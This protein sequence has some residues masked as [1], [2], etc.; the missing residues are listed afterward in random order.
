MP[1][2]QYLDYVQM[3][4]MS[5]QASPAPTP[6]PGYYLNIPCN[7]LNSPITV[8]M[9]SQVPSACFGSPGSP[10]ASSNG[11]SMSNGGTYWVPVQGLSPNGTVAGGL[12]P[13][14]NY[15]TGHGSGMHHGFGS[16][17]SMD[18][19]M[20]AAIQCGSGSGGSLS[21][22]SQP[23]QVSGNPF[24]NSM[25]SSQTVTQGEC[26]S[27]GSTLYQ[28]QPQVLTEL[29]ELSP[30]TTMR[31]GG[32]PAVVSEY[33]EQKLNS[34]CIVPKETE[35]DP[36]NRANSPAPSN[37]THIDQNYDLFQ[38][39]VS[40]GSV[41]V[42]DHTGP[43][44][45][46]RLQI[47]LPAPG[48]SDGFGH[49]CNVGYGSNCSASGS[50]RPPTIPNSSP[51]GASVT[52]LQSNR[53]ASPGPRSK[54]SDSAA[55]VSGPQSSSNLSIVSV[56]RTDSHTS[57]ASQGGASDYAGSQRSTGTLLSQSD[58]GGNHSHGT[59]FNPTPFSS[60][61]LRPSLRFTPEEFESPDPFDRRRNGEFNLHDLH[62]ASSS[63][64][65]P[66][67]THE[68]LHS[69]GLIE[70]SSGTGY[71]YPVAPGYPFG[72]FTQWPPVCLC[73]PEEA[74]GTWQTGRQ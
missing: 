26:Q 41:P 70:T 14:N 33:V 61:D 50:S 66:G 69:D 34:D 51:T 31:I 21:P 23:H 49:R 2:N 36:E 29:S 10:S 20:A 6:E 16:N 53:D 1:V 64:T 30:A 67:Q 17:Y 12:H 18:S 62:A 47:P 27:A 58:P 63:S 55:R 38:A 71:D 45:T 35:S 28:P 52:G 57:V 39:P 25:L 59:P 60:P 54:A 8:A 68:Q 3:S 44:P 56:A 72:P 40:V 32:P 13:G 46:E 74:D 5:N 7:A 11:N 43:V 42:S 9:P 73:P 37:C 4:Q 15:M 48:L 65:G 19:M 22:D 24:G